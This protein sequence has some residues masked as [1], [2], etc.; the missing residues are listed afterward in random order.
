[1]TGNNFT[2][3]AQKI[4]LSAFSAAKHLSHSFIGSEHILLA[5]A[6]E[7]TANACRA[8]LAEGI[9]EERLVREICARHG[10]GAPM[11]NTPSLSEE[12]AA[13]IESAAQ[14]ARRGAGGPIGD[15]HL[16]LA[17][18]AAEA[19]GGRQLLV[20]CGAMP[21]RLRGRLAERAPQNK[22]D[23]AKQNK[24]LKLTMQFSIDMTAQAE[25][26]TYDPVIGRDKEVE[27][28]IQILARR[29]KSN[30]V[31]VGPAG[32]GK[33]AI[34]ECVAQRIVSGDVPG[35][36][37]NKRLLSID[38]SAIVAGTKYRG[39]F[40]ERLRSI[41]NE[42]K[43]A[44][45][46]ILFI[47]ELHT[48]A[49]AGAAEGAVDAS[50]IL[51]PALSRGQLQVM[52]ATTG[53][54]YKKYIRRDSALARRFQPVDVCE[55]SENETESIL[56]ALKVRY[57]NH[58]GV[59]LPD[60]TIKSAVML[61][62][63]YIKDRHFPDKA[64]DLLDEAAAHAVMRFSTCAT[65][66]DVRRVLCQMNGV[67]I[68]DKAEN[69]LLELEQRLGKKIIGQEQAISA[70]ARAVRRSKAFGAAERPSGF[71]F[72]GPTGVGKT[73]LAR[74]LAHEIY[75]SERELIRFDMSEYMEK[76]SVSKLIGSPPGY[77]GYGE[78]GQLT[79]KIRR[80]PSSVVLLDEV[81]KAHPE[82]L[83]ILLQMLEDGSLTDGEGE[84]VSFRSAII[85]MTSNVG[86]VGGRSAGFGK[87]GEQIRR[88]QVLKAVN[89]TF[90]PELIGRMDEL[91]VF[92]PLSESQ[93]VK[94]AQLELDALIRR[95]ERAGLELTLCPSV[96][97]LICKKAGNAHLGARP[98]RQAV[99]RMVEDK[100]AE[101]WF[102]GGCSSIFLE[103]NDDEITV[104]TH[105]VAGG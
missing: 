56:K 81:E 76:H 93:L 73:S 28:V 79:E 51:K 60:E 70:V 92:E 29:Q 63:K 86:A 83:G 52:G 4:L 25:A 71:L 98:I 59:R 8:L 78:G 40:E 99:V 26:G 77:V 24:N 104:N 7:P 103:T 68:S 66:H 89:A 64:I 100:L 69:S 88:D 72:C 16:L 85:V 48:I 54:E 1:M 37:R 18:I 11:R 101:L 6:G 105:A 14:M 91:A 34:A 38:I 46:I 27:R 36:L 55:P 45:D 43:T 44:G 42:I 35:Y 33:T 74:A 62:S 15:E 22:S 32:V 61:S 17:I 87:S 57:E 19:C 23:Q 102:K 49:G 2:P 5:I 50:N 95:T 13:I 3:C 21:I 97:Q 65:E 67:D 84:Q 10:Y 12:G 80:R 20:N 39:E 9:N 90:P 94:I 47:D 53:G 75:G 82:V 30:P 31:L 96:A 58:H 41:V